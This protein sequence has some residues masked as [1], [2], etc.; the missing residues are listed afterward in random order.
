MGVP[1]RDDAVCACR[2][3]SREHRSED[4]PARGGRAADV[5]GVHAVD[6]SLQGPQDL[7]CAGKVRAELVHEAGKRPDVAFQVPHHD[8][9]HRHIDPPQ[10][11]DRLCTGGCLVTNGC[12]LEAPA[13][14]DIRVGRSLNVDVY[15]AAR[16]NGHWHVAVEGFDRFDD[17]PVWVEDQS[18][19][20]EACLSGQ[21][22]K[23]DDEFH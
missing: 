11:V 1:D 23:I 15:G 4:L 6:G 9:A 3:R 2:C 16:P 20:L 8:V 12:R 22:T 21:E 5:V 13:A 14:A 17:A 10:P 7:A 18:L 19:G